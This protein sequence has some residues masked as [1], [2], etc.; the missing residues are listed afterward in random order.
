MGANISINDAPIGLAVDQ[1][2][3]YSF[4]IT[5]HLVGENTLS[6]TFAPDIPVNG[7]FMACTGG[8]HP[9]HLKQSFYS[10]SE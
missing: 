6:V 7:R 10:L 3:R 8:K 9:Q 4:D 1:F 5:E 2:A